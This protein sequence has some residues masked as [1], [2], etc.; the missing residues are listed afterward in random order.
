MANTI[1]LQNHHTLEELQ[2]YMKKC[3]DI[4]QKNRL[5]V[6]I[7]INKGKTRKEISN[8][9]QINIDTITDWVKKY[10]EKGVI[11]LKTNKGGRKEGNP[12]W[13]KNIFHK[14]FK[15]IDKNNKYWSI[16]LMKEWIK[17][18]F[19]KNIPEQTIWYH[20]DMNRYS[21]KSARPHPY[22]GDLKQQELFKKGASQRYWLK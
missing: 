20:L 10:N 4:L 1:Q 16:P 6:I 18:N 13:D 11:G 12:K 15:E 2:Q 17:N 19:N 22:K 3:T 14:L 5:K 7:L 9:F 8:T 21:Y